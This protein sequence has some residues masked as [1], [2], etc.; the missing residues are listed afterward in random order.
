MSGIQLIYKVAGRSGDKEVSLPLS[1]SIALRVMTLNEV[2]GVCGGGKAV[3][4]KLPDAEDVL[5]MQRALD[6]LSAPDIEDVYIGDGGAPIRFFTALTASLPG[7]ALIVEGSPGLSR[8]PMKILIDTLRRAGA[9]IKCLRNEGYPPFRVMGRKIET[10]V[11]NIDAGIS[12]QYISALMLVAPLWKNGLQ[13]TLCGKLVSYPYLKM[14]AAIMDR[15][16]I[17]SE[18]SPECISVKNQ[19][20]VAPAEY[21]IEPDWSAASY[22]YE[23]ALLTP[24]FPIHIKSLIPAGDSLQGDSACERIFGRCGVRTHYHPDGSATL[25]CDA[26]TLRDIVEKNEF[27][28]ADLGD[29]PD[30][31]PALCV[32]FSLSGIKFRFCNVAHLRHKE[33]NRLEALANEMQKIGYMLDIGDSTL[34]WCG[35]RCPTGENESIDTYSDHRMA[36]AFAPAAAVLPYLSINNPEVVRK[37]FPKFWDNI[38]GLGFELRTYCQ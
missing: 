9:S 20:P 15:Y 25:V 36:M 38:A 23:L 12:S 19:L 8:R 32:G 14:T 24:G 26:A 33:S 11:L 22:F 34:S 31:V 10:G 37:S 16:G 27:F 17:E 5:G 29:T 7:K 18:L 13:L 21:P 35:R 30:L 28:E 1:K 6:A 4:P 3:I 2:S